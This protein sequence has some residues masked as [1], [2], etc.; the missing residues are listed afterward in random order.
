M[1]GKIKRVE[2]IQ[3]KSSEG[4]NAKF[5]FI[6]VNFGKIKIDCRPI[7]WNSSGDPERFITVCPGCSQ[8]QE[9]SK[10]FIVNNNGVQCVMCLN[11]KEGEK[12]Y[13]YDEAI[14][15]PGVEPSIKLVAGVAAGW[16]TDPINLGLMKIEGMVD[17]WDD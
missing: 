6:Y 13:N 7:S 15:V 17:D 12:E 10:E 8:A 14:V 9:F 1:I 16:F 3:I 5:E 11:C 2:K 4:M